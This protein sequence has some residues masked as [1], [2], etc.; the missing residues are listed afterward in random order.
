MKSKILFHDLKMQIPVG[1]GEVARYYSEL[2]YVIYDASYCRLH[3]ADKS[4]YTVEVSLQHMLD[5]LPESVF[6][7]CNRS[8]ILNTCYYREYQ[9]S[10]PMIKMDDETV[11]SL[12]RRKISEFKK[13]KNKLARISPPC[14]G[15]NAYKNEACKSSEVSCRPKKAR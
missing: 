12:S 11:F 13:M 9:L 1:T 10:P 3:F 6:F 2:M 14:P 8:V 5:N 15:C 7:L 4:K